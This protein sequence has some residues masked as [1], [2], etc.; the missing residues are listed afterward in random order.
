MS[1][2]AIQ[3]AAR[4]SGSHFADDKEA[5]ELILSQA[6]D[7]AELQAAIKK[8]ARQLC[9]FQIDQLI[10]QAIQGHAST[11]DAMR[12]LAGQIMRNPE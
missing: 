3:H 5:G 1:L 12:W 2:T 4:L 11:R 7:I 8:Q 6:A 9:T 10:E